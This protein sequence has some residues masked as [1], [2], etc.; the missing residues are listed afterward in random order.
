MIRKLREKLNMASIIFGYMVI[1]LVDWIL[2]KLRKL[3][4]VK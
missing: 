1:D 3:R 2:R 4:I